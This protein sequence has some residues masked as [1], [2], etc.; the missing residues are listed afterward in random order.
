MKFGVKMVKKRAKKRV[1]SLIFE[2]IH[3]KVELAETRVLL[4]KYNV[5]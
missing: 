5:F 1:K 4:Q 3:E 2:I